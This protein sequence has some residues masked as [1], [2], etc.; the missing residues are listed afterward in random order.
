MPAT[1]PDQSAK[2]LPHPLTT[3]LLRLSNTATLAKF[4][5]H[6]RALRR[7]HPREALVRIDGVRDGASASRYVGL[8]A[9]LVKAYDHCVKDADNYMSSLVVRTGTFIPENSSMR[10][11]MVV[12][13]VVKVHGNQG[14]VVCRF[15]RNLAPVEINSTVYVRLSRAIEY[16]E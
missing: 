10:L 8:E 5:S 12:G 11:K 2:V 6:R 13:R 7:L 1:L 14:V 4:I 9:V 3:A 15:E 16:E